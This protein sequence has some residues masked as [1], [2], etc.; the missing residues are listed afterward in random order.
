MSDHMFAVKLD[1]VYI[2]GKSLNMCTSKKCQIAFDSGSTFMSMPA[3]AHT[4]L[5]Q[6]KIPT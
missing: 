4:I 1:E 3:F 5:G 2:N 6:Q